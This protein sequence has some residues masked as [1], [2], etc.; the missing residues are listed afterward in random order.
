MNSLQQ[1][2][3]SGDPATAEIAIQSGAQAIQQVRTNLLAAHEALAGPDP[4]A[5][6]QWF[7]RQ[8]A[9]A[10]A[11]DEPNLPMARV[12]QSNAAVALSRASDKLARESATARLASMPSMMG[13]FAPSSPY[14]TAPQNNEL[15]GFLPGLPALRDWI[16]LRAR[17]A[18]E[19]NVGNRESDPPGYR[20]ALRVY[21][22]SI[23]KMRENTERR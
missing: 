5:A 11:Q 6:A 15:L 21:F 4:L 3:K 12:D 13:L 18:E 20:D 9:R 7:A 2:L 17:P 14:E 8:A 19:I 10:L 22:S 16:T 1:S 23:S